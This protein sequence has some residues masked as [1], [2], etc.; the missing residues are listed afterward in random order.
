MHWHWFSEKCV[1]TIATVLKNTALNMS[2]QFFDQLQNAIYM[3]GQMEVI[4]RIT[5]SFIG[6]VNILFIFK[7]LTVKTAPAAHYYIRG[8][9]F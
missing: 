8:L 9:E 4:G 5:F 3:Y 1:Y 2:A 7:T 6:T